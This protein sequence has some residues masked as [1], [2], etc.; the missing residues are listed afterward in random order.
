MA[1]KKHKEVVVSLKLLARLTI[2]HESGEGDMLDLHS[3]CTKVGRGCRGASAAG[4]SMGLTLGD[5]GN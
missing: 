4:G 2:S 3:L 1:S 5:L